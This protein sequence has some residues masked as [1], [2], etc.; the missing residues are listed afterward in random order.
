MTARTDQAAQLLR[1]ELHER[2]LQTDPTQAY[3]TA[4]ELRD[5]VDRVKQLL[6]Q[7]AS[8]AE[9]ATGHDAG[10]ALALTDSA[11]HIAGLS[12]RAQ[13]HLLDSVGYID[14]IH[15]ELGHLIWADPATTTGG[16]S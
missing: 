8:A 16:A 4:P 5:I 10:D 15:A 11:E 7:L 13:A 12:R 2:T 3:A 14:R 9:Q 6:D 1:E